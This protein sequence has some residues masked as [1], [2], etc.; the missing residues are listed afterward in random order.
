MI[1]KFIKK[2]I[3]KKY[4][5]HKKEKKEYNAAY[6]AERLKQKKELGTKMARHEAKQEFKIKTTLRSSNNFSSSMGG[7]ATPSRSLPSRSVNSKP[8]SAFG[9]HETPPAFNYTENTEPVFKL[10]DKKKR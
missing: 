4:A 5:Q 8:K 9:Y 10:N 6:T 7:N 1:F 2:A 3:K